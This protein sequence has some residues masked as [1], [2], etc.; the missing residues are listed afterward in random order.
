MKKEETATLLIIRTQNH[1]IKKTKQPNQPDT[2]YLRLPV[3]FELAARRALRHSP[4]RLGLRD[5]CAVFS[6][7]LHGFMVTPLLATKNLGF[8]GISGDPVRRS[9]WTRSPPGSS[10]DRIRLQKFDPLEFLTLVTHRK[11]S[12]PT[13]AIVPARRIRL[14]CQLEQII[15][16]KSTN[17]PGGIISCKTLLRVE[18]QN[19]TNF[20]PTGLSNLAAIFFDIL[21]VR[22]DVLDLFRFKLNSR[23]QLDPQLHD[24]V[25]SDVQRPHGLS[26]K[27]F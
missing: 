18:L 10:S 11:P 6:H 2:L 9:S 1:W 26:T 27:P 8:L 5:L 21:W 13:K 20:R 19:S 24:L 14:E 23:S 25:V 16:S 17:Q 12:G 4:L 15:G 7:G 3:H 22:K